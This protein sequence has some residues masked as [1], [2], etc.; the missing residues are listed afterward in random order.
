M[1]KCL[2]F[3]LRRRVMERLTKVL[4]VLTLVAAL[5]TTAS[6]ATA[7]AQGGDW[8][9]SGSWYAGY[10]PTSADYVYGYGA[11]AANPQVLSTGT[12]ECAWIRMGTYSDGGL[13]VTG[14][15]LNTYVDLSGFA[16]LMMGDAYA[17]TLDVS[18]GDVNLSRLNVWGNAIAHSAIQTGGTVDVAELNVG[19]W[20]YTST[21]DYQLIDGY[22]AIEDNVDSAN[23]LTGSTGSIL[24]N[25]T[26]GEL[27]LGNALL[28]DVLSSGSLAAEGTLATAG[29]L[30]S[31]FTV[32]APDAEHT[33][34]V[35]IPEP[36]TM[37]LLGLGAL[38]LRRKK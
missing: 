26:G 21:L 10:T 36:A 12:G 28:A 20:G 16:G 5:G 35:L 25:V 4:V 22:L 30:N 33:S 14:G 38:V 24:I 18:G 9:S 23:P 3:L 17:V 2:C 15:T 13:T 6:A 32:T 34:L 11:T 8:S 27:V 19:Q 1:Q 29:N 7:Y 37:V 31:L